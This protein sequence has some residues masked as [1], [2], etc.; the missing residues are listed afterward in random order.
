M[1]LDE[2]RLLEGVLGNV[3]DQF[4]DAIVEGRNIDREEILPYA[5]GRIFSGNQAREYGFVD[6]LGD[7]DEAIRLAARMADLEG[8]PSVVRKARRRV[9][10]WSF[11][12]EK[13]SQ[14]GGA[15]GL[16]PQGPKLEYRLR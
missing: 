11:V 16:S 13:L 2:R 6:R 15:A 7:L 10:F 4:V 9:S 5:D 8:R 1:T 3:Y 12:D 14:M